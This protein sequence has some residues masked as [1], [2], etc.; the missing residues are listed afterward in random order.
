LFIAFF[1]GAGFYRLRF[2]FN[3]SICKVIGCMKILSLI[4]NN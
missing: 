4:R 3:N 2:L 1:S